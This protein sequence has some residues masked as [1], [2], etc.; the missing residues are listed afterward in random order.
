MENKEMLC[1][2]THLVAQLGDIAIA[3][4]ITL[5]NMHLTAH[6]ANG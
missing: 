6:W 4:G 3:K 5:E 2:L 1:L